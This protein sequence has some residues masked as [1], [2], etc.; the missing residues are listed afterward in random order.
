[1]VNYLV[2]SRLFCN[3]LEIFSLEPRKSSRGATPMHAGAG[4]VSGCHSVEG[5]LTLQVSVG[6]RGTQV[7][8]AF[9]DLFISCGVRQWTENILG[10]ARCGT[11][12]E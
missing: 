3:A 9:A 7:A 8:H 10:N 1:M 11:P 5:H 6:E 12:R 2:K 4:V